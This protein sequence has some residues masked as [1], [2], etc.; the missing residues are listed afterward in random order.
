MQIVFSEN[1]KISAPDYSQQFPELS[2]VLETVT[3]D[4]P[5]WTAASY[6]D[7][8]YETAVSSGP[9]Y[10]YSVH[11]TDISLP[12]PALSAD[13]SDFS[14]DG[15]IAISQGA[16]TMDLLVKIGQHPQIRKPI[17]VP[18][19]A[20]SYIYR[21]TSHV[22][23]SLGAHIKAQ[24][25][26]LVAGHTPG[27]ETQEYML[28]T[29]RQ[30]DT[31]DV[32]ISDHAFIS[33]F[34]FSGVSVM[35]QPAAGIQEDEYPATLVTPRH[36]LIAAHVSTGAIGKKFAFRRTNGA[37]QTVTVADRWEH[38]DVDVAVIIFN[39]DVTGCAIY[40][41]MPENWITNYAPSVDFA[42][43]IAALPTIRKAQHL[44]SVQKWVS[45]IVINHVI[46]GS[47]V[48]GRLVNVPVSDIIAP[49][50]ISRSWGIDEAIGGDSAGPSFFQIEG[51]LVFLTSQWATIASMDFAKY[52]TT[53]NTAMNALATAIGDPNA[54]TYALSHPDLI[55]FTNYGV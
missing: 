39:A 41:T 46:S 18:N 4:S 9:Q 50:E 13:P 49:A 26:A 15:N 45:A 48:N 33:Q 28:T 12:N 6:R 2:I 14:V 3:P 37:Y 16:G 29:N 23:G 7:S 1:N 35:G 10:K 42:G 55:G 31:P 40:K 54:G 27:R 24:T 32:T 30:I 53:I 5:V 52:T 22:A 38:P 19:V 8:N 21:C 43:H 25:D 51:E 20:E 11:S 34:D 44:S 47:A 17:A 36:A